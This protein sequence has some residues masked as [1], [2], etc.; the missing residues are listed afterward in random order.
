MFCNGER[1]ARR[2]TNPSN[3]AGYHVQVQGQIQNADVRSSRSY[4]VV[5][6]NEGQEIDL[7]KSYHEDGLIDHD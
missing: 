3:N 6:D 1:F 7:N 4:K 5:M 2:V